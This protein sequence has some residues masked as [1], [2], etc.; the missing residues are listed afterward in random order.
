MAGGQADISV[1]L[2]SVGEATA[3]D[4]VF[5]CRH[6]YFTPME[7]EVVTVGACDALFS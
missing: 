7:M 1:I 5:V 6:R 2:V 3:V 4:A